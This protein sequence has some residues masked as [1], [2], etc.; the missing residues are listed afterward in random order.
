MAAG[1]PVVATAVG[2]VIDQLAD[3][4]GLLVPRDDVDGLA[5][6]LV[7]LAADAA[8]RAELGHRAHARA[9]VRYTLDAMVAAYTRL[10]NL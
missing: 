3:G 10:L 1:L 6:A 4:A 5:D 8:L 2:G 9:R 7:R